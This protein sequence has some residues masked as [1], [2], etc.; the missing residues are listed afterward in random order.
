MRPR[1]KNRYSQ[2]AVYIPVYQA[3]AYSAGIFVTIICNE[4]VIVTLFDVKAKVRLSAAF[5]DEGNIRPMLAS[6]NTASTSHQCI[7]R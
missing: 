3:P 7:S 5:A 6:L 4:M 1:C 2:A